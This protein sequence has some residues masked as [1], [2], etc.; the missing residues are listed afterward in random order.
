VI[1]SR[2]QVHRAPTLVRVATYS[3]ESATLVLALVALRRASGVPFDEAWTQ[4]TEW[5]EYLR[6]QKNQLYFQ[7]EELRTLAATFAANAPQ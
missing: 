2:I 6:R 5:F 4:A 3:Q 1:V 7:P